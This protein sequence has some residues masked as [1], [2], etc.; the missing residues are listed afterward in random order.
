MQYYLMAPGDTEQDTLNEAN[1]LG[2]AS[3]DIFWAGIGLKTLMKLVDTEPQLLESLRIVNDKGRTLTI[4]E[5]LTD[6]GK[7]KIRMR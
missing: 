4:S 7:L 5:F 1:L 2:E 6:I 3:F